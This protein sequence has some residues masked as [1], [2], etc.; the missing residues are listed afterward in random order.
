MGYTFERLPGGEWIVVLDGVVMGRFNQD[1]LKT[2]IANMRQF[3]PGYEGSEQHQSED[4]VLTELR[5]RNKGKG[6]E[7]SV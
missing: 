2:R 6:E 5:E 3:T 4:A 1:N 7:K